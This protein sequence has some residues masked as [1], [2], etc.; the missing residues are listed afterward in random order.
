MTLWRSWLGEKMTQQGVAV[1]AEADEPAH[2]PPPEALHDETNQSSNWMFN[3]IKMSNLTRG[4][5]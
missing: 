2:Q 3:L 4:H 5:S 1:E